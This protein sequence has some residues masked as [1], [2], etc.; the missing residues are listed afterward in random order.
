MRYLQDGVQPKSE[1]APPSDAAQWREAVQVP[2]LQEGVLSQGPGPVKYAQCGALN[3][4]RIRE[5]A[6]KRNL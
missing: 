4:S 1:Y 5:E 3:F 2:L 6:E